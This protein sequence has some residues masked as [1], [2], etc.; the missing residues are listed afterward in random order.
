MS[1]WRRVF[2]ERRTI[3]L[4]L[5][6]ALVANLAVLLLGVLPLT[7][8]VSGMRDD[9]KSASLNLGVARMLEK[10]A[11]D[12]RASKERADLELKRFYTEHL[13]RDFSSARKLVAMQFLAD[14][15]RQ[16]GLQFDRGQA[17]PADMRDSQL[18]RVTAKVTLSGDYN[19]IRKF[20]YAVET[21][22][23]FVVIERVALAQASDQQASKSGALEVTIDVATY[24]LSEGAAAR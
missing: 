13:P 3:L 21:A 15:A 18:Q 12:A 1:L 9:R 16:S 20:L 11:R 24:Y 2:Q 22:Q 17:E 8:G 23:E 5:M 6:I 19:S 10:Q 7:E 14:T 4:P